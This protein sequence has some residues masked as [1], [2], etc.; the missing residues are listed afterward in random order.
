MTLTINHKLQ[1]IHSWVIG[2]YLNIKICR[3]ISIFPKRLFIFITKKEKRKKQRFS[4]TRNSIRECCRF[5]YC[6]TLY[7]RIFCEKWGDK[8]STSPSSCQMSAHIIINYYYFTNKHFFSMRN[9]NQRSSCCPR[10]HRKCEISRPHF[11]L[12]KFLIKEIN[13]QGS[14]WTNTDYFHN[15]NLPFCVFSSIETLREAKATAWGKRI[16]FKWIIFLKRIFL[17]CSWAVRS[18]IL[19]CFSRQKTQGK[20]QF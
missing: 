14:V 8:S 4:H 19:E 11:S 20:H 1:I 3:V 18:Q 12:S 10:Q 6:S 16:F 5:I 17:K 2:Y 15:F 13:S 7:L 9:E